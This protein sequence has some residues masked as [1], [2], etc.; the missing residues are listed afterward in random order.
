MWR[1]LLFVKVPKLVN[2]R[3]T[4][5]LLMCGRP[6]LRETPDWV[7]LR[8]SARYSLGLSNAIFNGCLWIILLRSR[9]IKS[10][11]VIIILW[12]SLIN[13]WTIIHKSFF[14]DY[15]GVEAT[16]HRKKLIY[17]WSRHN[18]RLLSSC[19]DL[20]R[21]VIIILATWRAIMRIAFLYHWTI[22]FFLKLICDGLPRMIAVVMGFV[23]MNVWRKNFIVWY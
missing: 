1:I 13:H 14:G 8:R 7:E 3:V 5:D 4:I 18:D 12:L 2:Y 6:G 10:P 22:H 11:L 21:L 20:R 19:F 16:G 15:G 23:Y 17:D 9:S